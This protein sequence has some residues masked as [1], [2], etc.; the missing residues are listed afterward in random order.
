MIMCIMWRRCEEQKHRGPRM[1]R[2]S[3]RQTFDRKCIPDSGIRASQGL[4]R[5]EI[6]IEKRS[7]SLQRTCKRGNIT[8]KNDSVL[9]VALGHG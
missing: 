5:L 3:I 8:E 2:G 6:W 1:R 7:K 4:H 9:E